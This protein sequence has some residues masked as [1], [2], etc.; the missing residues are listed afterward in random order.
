MQLALLP[1]DITPDTVLA[2]LTLRVGPA[3]GATVRQLA[4][5]IIGT[6][7]DAADERLLRGVIEKLR[8]D[9]HPICA[10]PE[11]GYHLAAD[12]ADLER[13]CLFLAKRFMGTARR[14]ARM[15]GISIPNFYGQ[16]GLPV[17]PEDD[18]QGGHHVY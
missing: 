2:A 15:K 13:T 3:N 18:D 10:T 14:I 4:S 1:R 6:P 11:E 16:L 9:G 8:D 7:S 5:E 12:A 17:P